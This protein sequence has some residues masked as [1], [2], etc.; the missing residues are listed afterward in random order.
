MTLY[1]PPEAQADSEGRDFLISSMRVDPQNDTQE[2]VRLWARG[3]LVGILVTDPGD[4][5]LIAERLGLVN[6]VCPNCGM[7]GPEGHG[8][9]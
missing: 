5:A 6:R 9:D 7:H 1:L 3:K 8:H 4:G 2:V